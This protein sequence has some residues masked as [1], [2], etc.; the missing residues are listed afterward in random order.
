VFVLLSHPFTM[1]PDNTTLYITINDALSLAGDW[2]ENSFRILVAARVLYSYAEDSDW[3]QLSFPE[4]ER[5]VS[6]LVR[7]PF[8]R[9]H[10]DKAYKNIEFE[11]L[12]QLREF[13]TC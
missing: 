10:I 9:N 7:K 11:E 2:D 6:P 8:V 5:I 13:S 4:A 3:L 1:S 12:G